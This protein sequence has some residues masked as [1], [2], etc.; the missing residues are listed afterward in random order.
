MRKYLASEKVLICLLSDKYKLYDCKNHGLYQVENYSEDT[1]CNICGKQ[2]KQ[3]KDINRLKNDF[4]VSDLD[5]STFDH[6]FGN[7]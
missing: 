3:L 5:K 4:K 1:T 7:Y 2:G 6:I